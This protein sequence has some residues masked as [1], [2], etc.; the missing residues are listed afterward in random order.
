MKMAEGL[1]GGDQQQNRLSR[2]GQ[3]WLVASQSD[4]SGEF[5]YRLLD[6]AME[7]VEER[8]LSGWGQIVATNAMTVAI[9][10]DGLSAG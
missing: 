5:T 3:G 2:L 10:T 1:D 6:E 8:E 7:F 9:I 4:F